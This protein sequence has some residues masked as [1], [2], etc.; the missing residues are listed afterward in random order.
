MMLKYEKI[1]LLIE[2]S[3]V[4]NNLNHGSRLPNF[5]ELIETYH[6]SKSTIVKALDLLEKRGIIY[7]IQGSGVFVR[8][9]KR[10]GY[11]NFSEN[12]GF[13]ADLGEFD[14]TSKVLELSELIPPLEVR[15][16]LSLDDKENVYYVK[17]IRYINSQVLCIEE[18]YYNKAIIPY[19]NVEIAEHSIFDYCK[20]ALKLNISFSDK[21]IHVIKLNKDESDLLELNEGD[22]GLLIDELFYLSSGEAFDFS[23]TIYHYVNSQFFLQSTKIYS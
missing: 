2:E 16:H 14:I 18:S 1:A 6:V 7:Q 4:E 22:P 15:E 11:I 8:R 13:T 10:K 23:K 21:Y 9:K 20:T 19:L 12:Q 5:K 3:I 17:R